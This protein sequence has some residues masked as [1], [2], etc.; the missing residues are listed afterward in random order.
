MKRNLTLRMERGGLTFRG[1]VAAF[2]VAIILLVPLGML[3]AGVRPPWLP[4]LG[5]QLPPLAILRV[6]S[7]L[8]T[9]EVHLSTFIEGG[10]NHWQTKY[11]VHGEAHLGVDL[12]RVQYVAVDPVKRRA[13][14][15]LPLPHRISSKV[16]H[17]RSEE[18]QMKAK[19]WFPCDPQLV[20]ADVWKAADKKIERLSQDAAYMGQAKQHAEV[21]LG[22]LFDGVQWKVRFQWE[23]P[24]DKAKDGQPSGD[25]GKMADRSGLP[26]GNAVVGMTANVNGRP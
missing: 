2:L 23:S 6:M 7:E 18:M 5:P 14:I 4:P 1:M 8:V 13:V 24:D 15:R 26:A 20:R 11:L 21:V 17:E 22:Q 10:N 16:D 19:V 12:S 9:T 25:R 3:V